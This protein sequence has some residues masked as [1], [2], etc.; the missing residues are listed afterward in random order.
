[1]NGLTRYEMETLISFNVAE[2]DA[3]VYTHDKRIIRKLDQMIVDYPDTYKL[4]AGDEDYREYEMPK[5]YVTFS[6][7][8]KLTPEQIRAKKLLIEKIRKS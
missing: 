1:M 7:P 8:R 3:R 2:D 5:K 4:I 6:K